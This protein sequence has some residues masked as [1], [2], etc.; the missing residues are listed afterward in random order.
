MAHLFGKIP[1]PVSLHLPEQISTKYK[2]ATSQV[3][4]HY[5]RPAPL[6]Q[7]PGSS[8]SPCVSLFSMRVCVYSQTLKYSFY[9]FHENNGEGALSREVSHIKAPVRY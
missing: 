3:K 8:S 2:V 6:Y 5:T 7:A 1:Q 9:A 4:G